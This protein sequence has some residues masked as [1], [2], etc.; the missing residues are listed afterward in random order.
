MAQFVPNIRDY[1]HHE[2]RGSARKR[3]LKTGRVLIGNRL[4][5]DCV[6]R[7]MSTTGARLVFG[8]PPMLSGD[9]KLLIVST[10][11]VVPIDIVWQGGLAI[12]VRFTGPQR[13]MRD[14]PARGSIA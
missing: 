7:D 14:R 3:M 2:I 11:S 1:Q 13:Q 4:T 6:I 10:N 9:M 8:A 5:I 12:G